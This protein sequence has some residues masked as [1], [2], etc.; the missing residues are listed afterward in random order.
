MP[1]TSVARFRGFTAPA[2]LKQPRAVRIV[3]GDDE[4]PGLYRP[5]LIEAM[6]W[7]CSVMVLSLFPGLYRPGLIEA[8]P[9]APA[10]MGRDGVSGALPPRP[11]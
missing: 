5:G 2:S 7:N 9:T 10:P 3:V 11:H 8:R 4:F 1:T 6:I